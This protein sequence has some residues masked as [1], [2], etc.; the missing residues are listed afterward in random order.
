MMMG[1]EKANQIYQTPT[2]IKSW[3]VINHI[4]HIH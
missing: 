4:F 1:R 3:T 2:L